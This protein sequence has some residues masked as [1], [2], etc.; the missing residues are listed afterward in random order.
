ML[1]AGMGTVTAFLV[2]TF[3]VNDHYGYMS[4]LL[5]EMA[6]TDKFVGTGQKSAVSPSAAFQNWSQ[7]AMDVWPSILIVLILVIAF[8]WY[9]RGSRS[10]LTKPIKHVHLVMLFMVISTVFSLLTISRLYHDRYLLP[11]GMCGLM[12]C[13]VLVREF[14][15][16]IPRSVTHGVLILS[17]VFLFYSL[18]QGYHF[19]QLEA[20]TSRNSYQ[21]LQT[22][23]DQIAI[24][25]DV[26]EPVVIYGWPLPHPVGA[27]RHQPWY[28]EHHR[29]L[30]TLYPNAGYHVPWN[31]FIRIPHNRDHWDIAVFPATYLPVLRTQR[32]SITNS[33]NESSVIAIFE[34][35]EVVDQVE[36]FV[37]IV[38]TRNP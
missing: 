16:K 24:D 21:K 35:F 29:E 20:D 34:D 18:V 3:P 6:M 14:G 37:F 15:G 1:W 13:T 23:I 31:S 25:L 2:I 5:L 36:K 10:N 4:G 33:M 22:K 7:F 17:A 32:L 28:E 19:T 26:E 9:V 38:P 30:D 11:V 12:F 27:M 8:I